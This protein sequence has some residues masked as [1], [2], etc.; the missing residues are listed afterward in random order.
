MRY[1]TQ[2][3]RYQIQVLMKAGLN[4]TET[5]EIIGVHKAPISRKLRRNHRCVA[6][7]YLYERY[8]KGVEFSFF[9][10]YSLYQLLHTT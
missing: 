6:K 5:A 4:Q 1:Y 7:P 10:K 8:I 3:T 9:L 2:L